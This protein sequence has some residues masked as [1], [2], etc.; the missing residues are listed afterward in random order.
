M[1][2]TKKKAIYRKRVYLGK[3]E[4]GKPQY[5]NI[6]GK[7]EKEVAQL[8]VQLK[9]KLLKGIDVSADRDMFEV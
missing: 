9:L 8:A 6:Y 4:A 7:S 2:K 3:D 5:R 1:A